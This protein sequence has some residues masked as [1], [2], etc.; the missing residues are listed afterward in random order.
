MVWSQPRW[1]YSE[2]LCER[3]EIGIEKQGRVA[4]ELKAGLSA[5]S[6]AADLEL[7]TAELGTLRAER[8]RL[9]A[10]IAQLRQSLKE[11]S[12]KL[13]AALATAHLQDGA[14]AK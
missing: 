8:D 11:S 14:Q 7:A 3:I 1:F 4:H 9:K 6:L 2:G 13:D 10:D 5:E 12:E